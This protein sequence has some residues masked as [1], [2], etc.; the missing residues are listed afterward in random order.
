MSSPVVV[1]VIAQNLVQIYFFSNILTTLNKKHKLLN[2]D[3]VQ[4]DD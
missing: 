4:E 1:N 3:K 2:F